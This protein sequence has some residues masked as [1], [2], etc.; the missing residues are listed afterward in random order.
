MRATSSSP[1][2]IRASAFRIWAS[3]RGLGDNTVIAPYATALAAMVDPPAAARNFARLAEI[4]GRG[5]YGWYEALDY[6]K[7][8]LPDGHGCRHRARLHGA[9]PGNERG[10]DRRCASRWSDAPRFHAEPIIQATELLLQERMPRDVAIFRTEDRDRGRAASSGELVSSTAAPLHFSA[11]PHPAHAPSFERPI[12]G[13]DHRG[14]FGIQPVAGHCGH[15]MAR[16]RHLRQLGQLTSSFAICAAARS[17][18]RA[19][20]RAAPSR[21]VTRSLSP[22]AGPKSSGTTERS[23]RRWK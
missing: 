2:S 17:G 1:I 20:N 14:G 13:D 4:G 5:R 22:K 9:S 19:I 10:R 16:G 7:A 11:R 6:T 21:T 8:R 15:A 12:C 23:R 3:K 18:R